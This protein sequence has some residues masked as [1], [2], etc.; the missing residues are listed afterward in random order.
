[1]AYCLSLSGLVASG[2]KTANRF[3]NLGKAVSLAT[4]TYRAERAQQVR[5]VTKSLYSR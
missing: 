5:A 2:G 3:G 4:W 1:M